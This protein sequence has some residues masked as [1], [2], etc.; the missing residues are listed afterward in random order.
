MIIVITDSHHLRECQRLEAF[1]DFRKT[2]PIAIKTASILAL[3]LLIFVR[4]KMLESL[5][6]NRGMRLFQKSNVR[7]LNKKYHFLCCILGRVIEVKLNEQGSK[8]LNNLYN[9]VPL[10]FKIESIVAERIHPT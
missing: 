3:K 1:V 4:K 7:F 2:F 5:P 10:A 8:N 6:D 9:M